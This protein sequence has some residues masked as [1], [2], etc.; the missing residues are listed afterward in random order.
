LIINID[1]IDDLLE[2]QKLLVF[3]EVIDELN[4]GNAVKGS[5]VVSVLGQRVIVEGSVETNINLQCDRCLGTY[6]YHLNADINEI[7][8]K[9]S[10]FTEFKKDFELTASTFVEE[11]HE[12]TEINLTDL[13]YQEVIL[14]IPVSKLCNEECEG[15]EY[16]KNMRNEKQIDPRL[17]VFKTY[18]DNNDK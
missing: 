12:S 13:V 9:G 10:L 7:F 6:Q 2:K 4:N 16:L 1:E 8:L 18:F 11:L 5:L 3:D 14:N 17:D 15:D